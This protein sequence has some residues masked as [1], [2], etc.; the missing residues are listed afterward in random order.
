MTPFKKNFFLL[1]EHRSQGWI[2]WGPNLS[3]ATVNLNL[4]RNL[5]LILRTSISSSVK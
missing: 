5:K 1:I 2:K 4:D 3:S